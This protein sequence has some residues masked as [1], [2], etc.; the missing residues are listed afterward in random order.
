MIIWSAMIQEG[1]TQMDTI[2][3]D[4][5]FINKDK[6]EAYIQQRNASVTP[7]MLDI[8]EVEYIEWFLQA[9][10]LEE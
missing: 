8:Y 2:H 1:H 7:Q 9:S 6:A 5:S 3:L 4:K 10:V